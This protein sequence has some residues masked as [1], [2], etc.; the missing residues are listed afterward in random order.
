MSL[1]FGFMVYFFWGSCHT[2]AFQLMKSN[3]T[4][5]QESR[6]VHALS[7]RTKDLAS[8]GHFSFSGEVGGDSWE[9][10]LPGSSSLCRRLECPTHSPLYRSPSLL[11]VPHA[12]VSFYL[13][14]VY[15]QPPPLTMTASPSLIVNYAAEVW[16]QQQGF[17]ETISWK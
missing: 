16:G 3:S 17:H 6:E 7:C 2:G 8:S 5:G 12:Q 10:G 13:Q 1:H 11:S 14:P 15:A 9:E 4:F